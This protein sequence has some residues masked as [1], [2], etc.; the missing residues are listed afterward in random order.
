MTLQDPPLPRQQ[1][2]LDEA[3]AETRQRLADIKRTRK[4]LSIAFVLMMAVEISII[5]VAI[6]SRGKASEGWTAAAVIVGVGVFCCSTPIFIAFFNDSDDGINRTALINTKTE[7]DRL[8]IQ[9]KEFFVGK[10]RGKLAVY[11]RYRESMPELIARYRVQANRYKRINN[12]LQLFVI[13]GSLLVSAAAGLFGASRIVRL[14]VVGASLAVAISSSMATYFK[15]RE[16]GSQLQKTADLI[17]IEFRA[18]EFGIGP[19]AELSQDDALR[20]FVE[21]VETIRTEQMSR[22]RQLD[23]PADLHYIDQTSIA[24]ERPAI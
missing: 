3:I 12:T 16:R 10:S 13:V 8:L 23:Q 21:K 7:L 5:V 19:Y 20:L 2:A 14:L 17:E 9:K 6:L 24:V 11:A 1:T 18:V 22:Q 4:L 15:V